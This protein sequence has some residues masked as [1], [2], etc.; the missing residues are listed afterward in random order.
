MYQHARIR[1]FYS[2][3]DAI[4]LSADLEVIK[5]GLKNHYTLY[6]VISEYQWIDAAILFDRIDVLDYIARVV[7][8][9]ARDMQAMLDM[10][11]ETQQSPSALTGIARTV[12]ERRVKPARKIIGAWVNRLPQDVQNSSNHGIPFLHQLMLT[13][14]EAVAYTAVGKGANV[15]MITDSKIS[16][17]HLAIMCQYEKL[18]ELL[19][20]RGVPISVKDYLGATPLNHALSYMKTQG[21]VSQLVA[22]GALEAANSFY[23]YNSCK[24][25]N[26]RALDPYLKDLQTRNAQVHG[27]WKHFYLTKALAHIFD[28]DGVAVLRDAKGQQEIMAFWR[29]GMTFPPKILKKIARCTENMGTKWPEDLKAGVTDLCYFASRTADLTD[30]EYL[31]RIKEGKPTL[32][33]TGMWSHAWY[34]LFYQDYFVR[35]DGN[36]THP[37]FHRYDMSALTEDMIH[38]LRFDCTY[39]TSDKDVSDL[40]DSIIKALKLQLDARDSIYTARLRFSK[41]TVGNCIYKGIELAIAALVVLANRAEPRIYGTQPEHRLMLLWSMGLKLHFLDR[42]LRLCETAH[43]LYLPDHELLSDIRRSLNAGAYD[44]LDADQISAMIA[45]INLITPLDQGFV[46]KSGHDTD[47]CFSQYV[48][49]NQSIFTTSYRMLM[50]RRRTVEMEGKK[51]KFE[52]KPS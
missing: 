23:A 46:A 49:K 40:L 43:S 35:C 30:N 22:R 37:H 13:C 28:R 38:H 17:L 32:I 47:A 27:Q 25:V 36:L 4:N 1:Q 34:I 3:H 51:L 7:N 45:R 19:I 9:G 20:A 24:Q 8:F 52:P 2:L 12:A 41:Q 5:Y 18:A 6:D 39:T 14:G 21:I 10:I 50:D 31:S 44:V 42:Y 48:I 33:V 29:E 15:L 11:S 26:R 16:A